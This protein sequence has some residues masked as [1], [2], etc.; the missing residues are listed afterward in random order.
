MDVHS[1]FYNQNRKAVV[2]RVPDG[3]FALEEMTRWNVMMYID[4]R[5]IQKIA[6][7]NQ[8]QAEDIA[9]SFVQGDSSTGQLLNENI[10][11]IL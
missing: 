8:I 6:I 1:E 5:L 10:G 9:E 11:T 3:P 7:N 2:T 4:N